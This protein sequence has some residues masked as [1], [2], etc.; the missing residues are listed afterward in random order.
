MVVWRGRWNC[1]DNEE[2]RE[3]GATRDLEWRGRSGGEMET[4]AEEMEG[5][6]GATA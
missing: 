5:D 4:G 6:D 2:E 3:M 1:C